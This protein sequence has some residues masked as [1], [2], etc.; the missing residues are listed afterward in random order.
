[1]HRGPLLETPELR[2]TQQQQREWSTL[3]FAPLCNTPYT[4][5]GTNP[6]QEIIDHSFDPPADEN[7]RI[8]LVHN[9]R[10]TTLVLNGMEVGCESSSCLVDSF[11][12]ITIYGLQQS[13][14]GHGGFVD[15]V[16][17]YQQDHSAA[18]PQDQ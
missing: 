9:D 16:V 3:R 12:Q 14:P 17:V 1:M 15:D 2:H 4:G 6:E 5:Q 7:Y 11:D 8:H 10:G 18:P 13:N